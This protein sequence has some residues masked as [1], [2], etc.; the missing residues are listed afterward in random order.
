MALDR[1]AECNSAKLRVARFGVSVPASLRDAA[2]RTDITTYQVRGNIAVLTGK[3]GKVLV[4]AGITASYA[5]IEQALS[6][7]R[8]QPAR[9][10]INTHRHF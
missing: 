6:K 4:D 5:R 7:L 9:H 3:N 8:D 1:Y 2:T 10:L